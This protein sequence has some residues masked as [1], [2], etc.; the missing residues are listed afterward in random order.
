M[1]KEEVVFVAELN[2]PGVEV[3]WL[4]DGKEISPVGM[5]MRSDGK[6]HTLTI[7]SA[8]TDDIAEY[9]IIAADKSAAAK[10]T[11]DGKYYQNVYMFNTIFVMFVIYDFMDHEF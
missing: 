4:K 11:V 2:K 7:F 3:K 10:L 1:E 5:E 8:K 6:R 9:T